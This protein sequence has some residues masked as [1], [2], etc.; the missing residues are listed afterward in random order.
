[1]TEVSTTSLQARR[2]LVSGAASGIGRATLLALSKLG[3]E[4]VG[5]DV[6]PSVGRAH[7]LLHAD[8]CRQE[9]VDGLFR[10]V[11]AQF[12]APDILVSCAGVGI[13][14]RLAEGDPAKWARLLEVNVLGALRLIRAFVPAM[15]ANGGDVVIVSSVAAHSA[16]PWGGPYAASKSALETLAE[17]LRLEVLPTVRVATIA[18]GVVDTPFFAHM[19]SGN[20]SVEEVGFGAV[21]P[22]QVA[23][24]IAYIVSRPSNMA[25]NH[26]TVRPRGQAF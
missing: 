8:L 20:L 3:A 7:P 13:H 22:E 23:E 16:Y 17:T 18:P 6:A 26:L 25:I 1:M 9:D 15:L 14:E 5:T 24:L 4:V 11:Q 19:L 21:R 12:G 10:A 2:A